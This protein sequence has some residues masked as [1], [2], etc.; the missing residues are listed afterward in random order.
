M[1]RLFVILLAIATVFSLAA[2]GEKAAPLSEEQT[3]AEQ[4]ITAEATRQAEPAASAEPTIA[5]ETASPEPSVVIET[6]SPISY[7]F[8]DEEGYWHYRIRLNGELLEL[9]NDALLATVDNEHNEILYP[10]SEILDYFNV[11]YYWD[12]TADDFTT[13]INGVKVSRDCNDGRFMWFSNQTD[14]YGN[15]ITPRSINGVFYVPN[16]VFEHTIG[17]TLT[18]LGNGQED[19]VGFVDITTNNPFAWGSG[20]SSIAVVRRDGSKYVGG[21]D[22]AYNIGDSNGGSV[23]CPSCNGSGI[24]TCS[25]CGGS[26]GTYVPGAMVYDPVSGTMQQGPM[27]FN[28]CTVCNGGGQQI[29]SACG[30]SGRQ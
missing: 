7:P 18:K 20:S 28:R 21:E 16:Y 13:V 10:L 4:A 23:I 17:A 19:S 1:K 6:I 5:I 2:C 8:L 29:C 9:E 3:P 14:G 27:T 30:G 11:S 24:R 12:K 25:F 22:D 15:S 26:G